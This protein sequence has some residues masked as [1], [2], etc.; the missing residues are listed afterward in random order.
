MG[1]LAPDGSP[2]YIQPTKEF[3]SELNEILLKRGVKVVG[4][5][6]D[7]ACIP[8]IEDSA[9]ALGLPFVMKQKQIINS[10][11]TTDVTDVQGLEQYCCKEFYLFRNIFYC[12]F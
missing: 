4:L 9:S 12:K 1:S 3:L 2:H 6:I 5:S 7:S 10:N 11:T 8:G